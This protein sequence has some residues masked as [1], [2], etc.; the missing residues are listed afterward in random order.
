MDGETLAKEPETIAED[1]LRGC[2]AIGVFVDKTPRETLWAI[3]RGWI[4]AWREGHTWCA[5]KS[6][7]RRRYAELAT[8]TV[9]PKTLAD[10]RNKKGYRRRQ[11]SIPEISMDTKPP[12]RRRLA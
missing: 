2:P 7:I 9:D 8:K 5:L 10:E 3:E 6:A 12:R 1:I 11:P 4:P